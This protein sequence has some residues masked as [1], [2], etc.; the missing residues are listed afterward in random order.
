VSARSQ[1]VAGEFDLERELGIA[2]IS[3][4]TPFPVGPVNV[5]LIL[6]DPPVLID[7]GL[8]GDETYALLADGLAQRGYTF[9][10]LGAII[11][12]HGHRD[13]IGLL[14]RLLR[15][16]DI[17]SYGHPLVQDLGRNIDADPEERRAF[18][19][20]ILDEF[21]VPDDIKAEA[22]SL[23]DRFRAFSEPFE[24]RHA[25]PDDGEVLGHRVLYVPGH[26]PS[27]TLFIQRD[28]NYSITGDCILTTT[29]PNPLLRRPGPGLPRDKA[30]LEYRES[31][32]R[33][34]RERLGICLPGH[35]PPIL[36]GRA[37]IDDILR[38]QDIRTEQVRELVVKGAR[39]PYDVSR[40]LF[41]RL[42]IPQI[43]L[44]LS[45]AVGHLE[46]LE[47]VGEVHSYRRSG[48]LN[49]EPRTK[50]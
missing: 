31:L 50:T 30:L 2:C 19:I 25:L 21:G 9:G 41:P 34:R 13:H 14:G 39:T 47:E 40:R 26:S 16:H 24:L 7:T 29:N 18:F 10:D 15:E 43:H 17:K 1:G 20:G 28:R 46:L 6:S 3:L 49:Y 23:Y 32:A 4:P 44:G 5:Y 36:D 37:A 22:N 33:A 8:N 38:K 48:V 35:G 27:D 45:I 11:V 42:P 12:T